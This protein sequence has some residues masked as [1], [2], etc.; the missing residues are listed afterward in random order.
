[1]KYLGNFAEWIDPAVIEYLLAHDGTKRPG[2]GTNPDS[3]E[4]RIATSVG[5]D[6]TN[7]YWHHYDDKSTPLKII[8]PFDNNKSC[9]WWF[10][11][12]TPGQFMPMHRDPHVTVDHEKHNCTRYWMPLQ[13]YAP[14]H[15]FVYNNE[16]M[17]NYRAGDLW[18]YDD[19]N[20]IHGACN[21]GYTPRLTFQFTTYNET[22]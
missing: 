16:F 19:A 3:E 21:I 9:M 13:D 17:S 15:I 22:I 20:E 18:S 2:G 1:M 5:Y 6:L 10:I 11:K 12:M 8:P 14:G 4:F 7:T